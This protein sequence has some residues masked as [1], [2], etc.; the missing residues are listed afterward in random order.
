MMRVKFGDAGVVVE[1]LAAA[2]GC[3]KIAEKHARSAVRATV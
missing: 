3:R 2:R 1:T